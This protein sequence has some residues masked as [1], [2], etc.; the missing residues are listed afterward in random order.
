MNLVQNKQK[1]I[2]DI[3][4]KLIDE[5]WDKYDIDNSGALDREETKRFVMETLSDLSDDGCV[6]NF[7]DS[8]FDQCF[9]EFDKDGSGTIERSEMV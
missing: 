4:A 5:I 1:E 8:E 3:I 7:S 9:A 6:A 2:D